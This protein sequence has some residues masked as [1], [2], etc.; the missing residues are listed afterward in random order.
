M[1]TYKID[2]NI[3]KIRYV[4]SYNDGI[5]TY[6]DGSLFYDVRCFS[7]KKH[8]DRMVKGLIKDGYKLI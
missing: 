6:Q 8:L 3:G 2:Y 1:K 4:L 5:K 7:N